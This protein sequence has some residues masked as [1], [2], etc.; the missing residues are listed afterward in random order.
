MIWEV[1]LFL[2]LITGW[3]V[4]APQEDSPAF[5]SQQECEASEYYQRRQL[6]MQKLEGSKYVR[7]AKPVCVG[8]P[9]HSA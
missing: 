2:F 8:I 9:G 6:D 1:G 3:S 7:A 4:V 5:S